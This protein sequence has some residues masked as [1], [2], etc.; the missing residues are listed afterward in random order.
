MGTAAQVY[1]S[2]FHSFLLSHLC[3]L[4]TARLG[5]DKIL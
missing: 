1:Q 5:L 3:F 4:K 2:V